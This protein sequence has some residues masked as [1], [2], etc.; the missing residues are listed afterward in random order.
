MLTSELEH[1]LNDAFHQ[2]REARLERLTIEHLLL[3][4]L[5]TPAVCEILGA[6]QCDLAR[7]K[8]ELEDHL[9]LSTAHL[10]EGAASEVVQPTPEFKRVLQRAVFHVQSSGR[11]D[12]GVAN[13]LL[14]IFSEPHS[15]AVD[16]LS[17]Q[18][19]TRQIVLH[20]LSRDP[21]RQ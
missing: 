19:V 12:A 13:V 18:N 2:A 11:K 15:R 20:Q 16:L 17:R 21:A 10:G 14:A 8:Q 9:E 3:A 7:L 4:I 1:C 5:E 6:C